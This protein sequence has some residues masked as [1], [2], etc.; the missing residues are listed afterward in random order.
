MKNGTSVILILIA[1][2][3]TLA[4]KVTA[5]L[6]LNGPNA[7][8]TIGGVEPSA[9]DPIDHDVLVP[10]PGIL[11]LEIQSGANPN[12]GLILLGSLVDPS[13][14][15]FAA[16]PWGGSI[17]VGTNVGGAVANVIVGGDGIGL[18]NN[19]VFD[20]FYATDDGNLATMTPPTFVL[21]FAAGS[22]LDNNHVAFQAIVSDPTSPIFPLDNTEV[23]DANFQTGQRINLLTGEEGVIPV[24][25][26]PSNTF[27]FHGVS[28][29]EAYICANGFLNFGGPTGTPLQGFTN[30]NVAWVQDQP[31]ISAVLTD[32]SPAFQNAL[33]GVLYEELGSSVR[34]SW[35]DP[36]TSLT[37]GGISHFADTDVNTVEI[38]MELDDGANPSEGEF[39]IATPVLDPLT[40]TD[41]GDGLIG[42]T[43][44]GIAIL[45][46]AFDQ[47]L[48]SLPISGNPNEAQFE[49]HDFS[50]TNVSNH[51]Y[52]GAGSLR[53]YNN[54][55]V[56]WN[57]A[58][59]V[60]TPNP[61]ITT[62]GDGGYSTQPGG[63]APSDDVNGMSQPSF[64]DIG[65][66]TVTIFGS[67][68]GFDPLATG[69]GTVILDAAGI[70]GGPFSAG[71]TGI[72]DNTGATGALAIPNAVQG[73]DRDG[74]GLVIGTPPFGATGLI[75]MDVNFSTGETFS[76]PVNVVASGLVVASFTLGDDA[77]VTHGLTVPI[78]YYGQSYTQVILNAN[79]YVTFGAASGDFTETEAKFFN[80]WNLGPNPG[81]GL[82]YSD[83]NRGGTTSGAT[84][85]VLED[86]NAGTVKVSYLN[87]NHWSSQEPAGDILATFGGVGPNSVVLDYTG[88]LPGT[89]STDDGIIGVT[90]GDAATGGDTSLSNAMGTGTLLV[91]GTFVSTNTP[92]S[93][94]ETIPAN[95][96]IGGGVVQNPVVISYLDSAGNGNF[97]IF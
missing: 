44:G 83:F 11:N 88:F 9:E 43:P 25:F 77:S 86:M 4:T 68:F 53:N 20:L 42:Q 56:N 61:S 31:G 5:Q 1:A 92:D 90:D 59:V 7:R 76:V 23:G 55:T 32:W 84:F 27:N 13:T 17:D 10:V 22:P 6:D 71:V 62:T 78:T 65:G 94:A 48:R 95:T 34:V 79:G 18:S 52:N 33:D 49:E 72:L 16:L 54:L 96:A 66:E 70:I 91:Q 64:A 39:T 87:Q 46:G 29:T 81:V 93:I 69:A 8:L 80:G 58:E 14:P 85:D 21:N 15:V 38:L 45:G 63:A 67:F 57:G 2:S 40:V 26:L 97:V 82:F 19:P 30:D 74:Q 73:P 47:H 36:T 41:Y 3:M 89:T 75:T 37:L 35:G 51:G 50:S 12:A 28:Y 60:F 24:A